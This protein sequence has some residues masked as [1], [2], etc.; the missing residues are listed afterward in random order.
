MLGYLAIDKLQLY[1]IY[2][3]FISDEGYEIFYQKIDNHLYATQI[4]NGEFSA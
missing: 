2:Q 1:V 3:R 4:R